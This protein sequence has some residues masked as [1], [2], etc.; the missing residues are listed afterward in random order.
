MRITENGVAVSRIVL[1]CR[2]TW[3]ETHAAEQLRDAVEKLS[4]AHLLLTYEQD[5]CPAGGGRI[6]V[7]RPSTHQ[8]IARIAQAQGFPQESQEEN[9]CVVLYATEEEL[10]LSGTNDR[11]VY[12][13]VFHLLQTQFHVGYY[14]DGDTYEP[15]KDLAV[16][17]GLRV[18]RSAFR[19]R[20]TV[21]QW[22]YN[23][24][25]LLNGEERRRELEFFARNKINSYRFYT[26]NS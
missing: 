23:F 8:G 2:T 14:F 1:G 4:G 3:L 18:E 17:P 6:L 22:V 13:S 15:Q 25:A 5:A 20:H 7:G 9:D 16:P 10:A 21:G 26:W 11:S 24:A 19:F 12:Y